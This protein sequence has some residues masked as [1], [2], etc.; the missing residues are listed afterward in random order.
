M[1]APMQKQ[2]MTYAE[3]LA[4]EEKSLEKHEWLNGEVRPLARGVDMSGGTMKHANLIARVG[5]FIGNALEG[6]PCQVFVS[7]LKVRIVP[8]GLA[9]YPD[10]TVLC[11]K[12]E[13]HPDDPETLLNPLLI[14]EV[15]SDSTEAYDRGG[16]SAHYRQ[17]P[18]LREYVLVSQHDRRIEVFRRAE[19]GQW[20]LSEYANGTKVELTSI[21]CSVSVD[22]VYGTWLV[23]PVAD[24]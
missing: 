10:V 18:S 4:F 7:D 15:L 12:A 5:R 3:Y 9:T 2:M 24:A 17:I 11:G 16:K 1:A 20:A 14:V 22:E 13:S 21:G 8:T 19:N 6:R 23:A